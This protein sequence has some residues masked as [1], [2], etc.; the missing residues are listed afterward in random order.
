MS[1]YLDFVDA[2]DLNG[3]SRAGWSGHGSHVEF[4]KVEDIPITYQD[5]LGDGS[6]GAVEK[7]E[8]RRATGPRTVI[9]PTYPPWAPPHGQR[10][11][12]AR[13]HIFGNYKPKLETIMDEVRHLGK[14]NHRHII[15][16]V[17]THVIGNRLS[18]LLYSAG[19]MNLRQILEQ[20]ASFWDGNADP[21]TYHVNLLRIYGC[22]SSGVAYIH[23]S[24]TKH[25]DVKAENIIVQ[26]RSGSFHVFIADFGLA[27]SFDP[28]DG[29]R[30]SSTIYVTRKYAAPEILRDAPRGRSADIFSLGCLFSEMATVLANEP[31][32]LFKDF[33]GLGQV[34]DHGSRKTYSDCIHLVQ[35]RLKDMAANSGCPGAHLVGPAKW[36]NIVNLIWWMLSEDP[37]QRPKAFDIC[38]V[39]FQST[40][41]QAPTTVARDTELYWRTA[42]GCT[43]TAIMEDSRS[44]WL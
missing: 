18:I 17:G 1:P 36:M 9:L 44:F 14:M 40:G 11:S 33:V 23:R 5:A 29:S 26:L 19:D 38:D 2:F 41:I 8:I 4:N 7:V 25:L 21:L 3:A 27:R 39:I 35:R 22:I 12:V 16:L 28:N 6:F 34:N 13:K 10:V 20:P 43:C 31:M 32:E 37:E 30:S 42:C 15:Q 24:S